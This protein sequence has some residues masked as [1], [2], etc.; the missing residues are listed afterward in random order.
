MREVNGPADSE[1]VM[2]CV[3]DPAVAGLKRVRVF[4]GEEAI[5]AAMRVLKTTEGRFSGHECVV[6]GSF[7]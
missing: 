5:A 6:S 3:T 7:K 4:W 2:V 1:D